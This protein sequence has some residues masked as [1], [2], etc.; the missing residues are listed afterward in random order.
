VFDL[1]H[2]SHDP[3]EVW[4]GSQCC[5]VSLELSIGLDHPGD[6]NRS[7]PGV[8]VVAGERGKVPLDES[9]IEA[10][11]VG[12]GPAPSKVV[13]VDEGDGVACVSKM[14]RKHLADRCLADADRAV[15][16]DRA[17]KHVA[18]CLAAITAADVG[19]GRR[20]DSWEVLDTVARRPAPDR[21]APG[22]DDDAP[23][24]ARSGSLTGHAS[25]SE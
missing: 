4:G 6:H 18:F 8:D 20:T 10:I 12:P 5:R 15:Q 24:G 21:G 2:R 1:F 22:R 3:H 25:P 19:A 23:R 14:L 7:G 17:H 11:V 9:G 16:P 13:G